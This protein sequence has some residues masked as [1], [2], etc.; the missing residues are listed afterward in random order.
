MK[1]EPR[2]IRKIKNKEVGLGVS[3]TI[4]NCLTREIKEEPFYKKRKVAKK[5]K[6]LWKKHLVK[7][8]K[9]KET[10]RQ[11]KR[12]PKQYKVYIKSHW[13]E[14]RKNEY[15]KKHKKICYR[16][17]SCEHIQLH[18]IKY[19]WQLFG[20]EPD[21]TLI[22]M[23]QKCH[24]KFHTIYGVKGNMMQEMLLFEQEHPHIL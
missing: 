8:K 23:C 20:N 21:N 9:R 5:N 13:W 4:F 22:P 10:V 17:G 18:H 16:C 7:Q 6:K 1:T 11:Y 14:K 2:Y 3:P 24:D 19:S 12:V 15:W